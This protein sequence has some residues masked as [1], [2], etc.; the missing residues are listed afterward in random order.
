VTLALV[1]LRARIGR[2]RVQF[3]SGICP[4]K[5]DEEGDEA[6]MR[7][8]GKGLLC[9]R[10]NSRGQERPRLPERVGKKSQVLE[11]VAS[12]YLVQL[13]VYVAATFPVALAL[14]VTAAPLH[15]FNIRI[16]RSSCVTL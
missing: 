13:V 6:K 12:S 2:V 3:S 16:S 9:V 1:A 10:C 11:V 15:N 4:L 5:N 7:M 14:K 8:R